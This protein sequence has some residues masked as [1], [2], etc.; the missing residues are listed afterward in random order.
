MVC[1]AFNINYEHRP[2][3]NHAEMILGLSSMRRCYI[4]GGR[5]LQ[6][7]SVQ[8]GNLKFTSNNGGQ[9]QLRWSKNTSAVLHNI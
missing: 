8:V 2:T 4:K 3:D 9:I 6:K 7:V 1:D 5:P